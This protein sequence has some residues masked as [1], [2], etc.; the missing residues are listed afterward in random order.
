MSGSSWIHRVESTEM[1]KKI[2]AKMTNA[3]PAI[4]GGSDDSRADEDARTALVNCLD[5][6]VTNASKA[7]NLLSAMQNT[8]KKNDGD[9]GED[10]W[11]GKKLP[12]YVGQLDRA[13]MA[14][15]LVRVDKQLST[16]KPLTREVLDHLEA[17]DCHIVGNLFRMVT[18]TSAYTQLPELCRRSRSAAAVVFELRAVEVGSLL[19]GWRARSVGDGDT[20]ALNILEGAAYKFTFV[21]DKAT[22]IR[23]IDGTEAPITVAIT[24][25]FE[26]MDPFSVQFAMARHGVAKYAL[27]EFFP[28]DRGP[29]LKLAGSGKKAQR[30]G[31]RLQELSA[32]VER[33]RA[34][35][36]ALLKK[37][38]TDLDVEFVGVARKARQTEAL[39]TASDRAR[40]SA[41]RQR[42][43]PL[44]GA[45]AGQTIEATASQAE[46]SGN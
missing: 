31:N 20:G 12:Q 18:C 17:N 34:V 8:V 13:W 27:R 39:R 1:K 42:V 24:R 6:L 23:F 10:A 46:V 28:E 29:N 22:T 11:P 7:P 33:D 21:G 15:W 36:E 44:A 38:Y 41:R 19:R 3:L 30:M 45:N 37:G 16:D 2:V 40:A 32:Q 25:D 35:A 5:V 14:Q 9:K 26:I 43:I 4:A